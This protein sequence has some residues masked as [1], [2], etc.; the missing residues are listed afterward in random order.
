MDRSVF[1]NRTYTDFQ[2]LNSNIYAEMDAVHSIRKS[3]KTLLTLF[4]PKAK[5]FLAFLMNRCAK[6]A[7]RFAYDHLKKRL[8]TYEFVFLFE[9]VLTNHGSKF[10]DYES[11]E[12]G[13]SEIQH[14]CLYYCDPIRNCQKRSV[15]NVHTMLCMVLSKGTSFEFLT[16]W[17][18]NLIANH[19]NYTPLECLSGNTPYGQS[20]ESF[21]KNTLKANLNEPDDS[22]TEMILIYTKFK[23]KFFVPYLRFHLW[24]H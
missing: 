12:T 4:F 2:S 7:V 1:I 23:L 18:V 21:G 22:S 17:D 3:K 20:L 5:L 14:C 24:N 16:Q 10:G 8:G 19:I 6:G 11:L 15:E 13:T 9:Y